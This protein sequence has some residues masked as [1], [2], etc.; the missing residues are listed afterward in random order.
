LPPHEIVEE[1]RVRRFVFTLPHASPRSVLEFPVAAAA[2]LRRLRAAAREFKP[3][4][5][6]VQCFSGNGAYA[7][8]VSR[9]AGIP[10]VVSLQGE[11]VMDD[12]DIYDHSVVLR[13]CLRAGLRQ[14]TAVTGC[15]AF[16]LK[17]AQARFR[18]DTRKAEVVYNGVDLEGNEAVPVE[19]PFARYVLG[20]G[21]VVRKKGFDLLL[22]AFSR[23][24]E[25]HPD[26]GLVI[27]GEGS[28]REPLLRRATELGL[29]ERLHMPGRMSQAEVASVMQGAAAFVMPSRVEPFGIVVLEA[30]RAG[31]PVVVTSRGG[32]PEFVTHGVS[33]LVVDPSDPAALASALSSL[34][35][36]P[37]LRKQLALAGQ[38][39]LAG[40]G[41][42]RITQRYEALYSRLAVRRPSLRDDVRESS[43]A[44][45]GR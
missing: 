2:T 43:A 22:D 44:A 31:V 40:F 4:V 39:Q 9:Q 16:T 30:W 35:A 19:L 17:D 29:S 5:L 45:K 10:L 8:V 26:V 11:T 42:P 28:E 13:T 34:L 24:A 37:A 36:S 12:H 38:G 32:P 41:W 27:A 3:D 7:T 23:V 1:T 6:H 33:G 21:R 14:A 20:L 15:S 18:L 25:A